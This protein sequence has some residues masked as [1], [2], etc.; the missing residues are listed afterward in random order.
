MGEPKSA[1]ARELNSFGNFSIAFTVIS[2]LTGLL[3]LYGYGLQ[4]GGPVI[5]IWSWPVVSLFTLVIGSCLAEIC[6]AFPHGSSGGVYFWT[7]QILALSQSK[8]V[9]NLPPLARRADSLSDG[10]IKGELVS[11]LPQGEALVSSLPQGEALVSSLP[12]GEALVSSLESVAVKTLKSSQL[13]EEAKEI[14]FNV[15]GA[16]FIDA[17]ER[18]WAAYCT[19]EVAWFNL[20]G[21]LAMT[22]GIDY[23]LSLMFSAF[24][25]IIVPFPEAN[26]NWFR[27]LIYF[28]I[29]II[30]MG[31]N[32]LG[33]RVLGYFNLVSVIWHVL[34]TC[35][36]V[37]V[38][39][40]TAPQLAS[41]SFVFTQFYNA[42]GWDSVVYVALLGTLTAQFTMTGYDSSAHVSEETRCP[43]KAAPMGII[44]SIAISFI[45][46]WILLFGLTFGIQDYERTIAS[47]TGFAVAQIFLDCAGR[48]GAAALMVIVM[49]AVFFAGLSSM[50]SNARTSFALARDG[51][52]PCSRLLSRVTEN[53]RVPFNAGKHIGNY[54]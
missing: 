25:N 36:V 46:G 5:L 4:T 33:V 12:Q 48:P 34:G 2:V 17:K 52:L 38:I 9:H 14:Q 7:A 29:L 23:G 11:S 6:S 27:F 37:S 31:I 53:Q 50:A 54:S 47:E 3:I 1:L 21:Q 26:S 10:L 19:W 22:A 45:V 49:G 41:S 15:F 35:T 43:E 28:L 42:T 40:A 39:F 8:D 13:V 30:H 18:P 16:R 32:S 51:C 20:L 44:T 24:L